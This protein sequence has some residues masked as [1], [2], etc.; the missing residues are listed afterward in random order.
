[1]EEQDQDQAPISQPVRAFVVSIRMFDAANS[2]DEDQIPVKEVHLSTIKNAVMH[3]RGA[4]H[5]LSVLVGL[6]QTWGISVCQVSEN[7]ELKFDAFA[8]MEAA[9]AAHH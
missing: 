1:M 6:L 4:E 8:E 2:N 7:G 3:E 5:A 9:N